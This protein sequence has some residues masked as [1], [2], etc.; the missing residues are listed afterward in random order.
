MKEIGKT[1]KKKYKG[2]FIVLMEE[3]MKVNIKMILEKE[4]ENSSEIMEIDMKVTLKMI[5]KK[6]KEFIIIMMVK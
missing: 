3:Y 5:N 6:E 1:I 4:K 2:N